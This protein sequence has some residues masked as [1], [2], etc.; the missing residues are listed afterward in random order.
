MYIVLK[1]IKD[2]FGVTSHLRSIQPQ[3]SAA[4]FFKAVY[5]L[6]TWTWTRQR[7]GM[8]G[9]LSKHVLILLK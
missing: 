4:S 5:N 7:G 1:Q 6:H 8:P 9:L 3:R 2:V